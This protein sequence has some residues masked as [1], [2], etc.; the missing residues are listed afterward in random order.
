[1]ASRKFY[2]D[3]L[4]LCLAI[5]ALGVVTSMAYITSQTRSDCNPPN[6]ST[7][8]V[9]Y[10][11]VMDCTSLERLSSAVYHHRSYLQSLH[12]VLLGEVATLTL[13]VFQPALWSMVWSAL[14]P[15]RSLRST[16]GG[17]VPSMKLAAL[18]SGV[19]LASTPSLINSGLYI[20]ASGWKFRCQ[21]EVTGVFL[22]AV[23]SLVSPIIVSPIYKSHT[24]PHP[25]WVT[26]PNGGG[27]GLGFSR[28][29]NASDVI[30]ASVVGGRAIANSASALNIPVASVT[31]D[32]SVAPF[33]PQSFVEQVWSATVETV[34]ARSMLDCNSSAPTRITNSTN[35]VTID[36]SYYSADFVQGIEPS[37]AGFV[38]GQF[39][40]DPQVTT[41]YLN[42]TESSAPGWVEMETSIIFLAANGTL[43]NAQQT[44]YPPP[45]DVLTSSI[46]SLDVLVCTSTTRLEISSCVIFNGSVTDC[47]PLPMSELESDSDLRNLKNIKNPFDVAAILSASPVTSVYRFSDRLPMYNAIT[48][49]MVQSNIPP[50][51]YL[52]ANVGGPLYYIPLSYVKEVLFWQMA[53][54]MVQGFAL[55]P[56]AV[57]TNQ[58]VAIIATFGTSH[59]W[60]LCVTMLLSIACALGAITW[61]VLR[62]ALPL[63]LAR[64]L[65]ISRNPH[66]D[67]AFE[68]YADRNTAMPEALL[69]MEV[70]YAYVEHLDRR[71]LVHTEEHVKLLTDF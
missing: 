16:H 26:F 24:G 44:I 25:Q 11:T 57:S 4:F 71:V 36:N 60:L 68:P 51:A 49:D 12:I 23:F 40:N 46:L 5:A 39:T 43:E 53:Q 69:E 10:A 31:H 22:I 33:I 64:L 19:E 42:R 47:K 63:D 37:F 6:N 48:A 17:P 59:P 38:L 3:L 1:M 2:F 66:L 7:S 54:A 61:S 14:D 62:Q 18:Q 70:N 41:V 20:K 50:L 35:I 55:G 45:Q 27:V 52:T 8:S 13:S 9:N 34:V 65:A 32:L 30:P 21:W 58:E 28:Q 15:P 29:L 67:A 56:W